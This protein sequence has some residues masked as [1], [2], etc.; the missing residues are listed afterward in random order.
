MTGVD[1]GY[2]W[3]VL[4][5]LFVV[6]TLVNYPWEIGQA[7]L[8]IGMDYSV[9]MWWHCFVASLGDGML[10]WIIYGVGRV[11]LRRSDW[12][13]VPGPQR[14]VVM[15]TSGLIIG[16][17]V[18]WLATHVFDRWSYTDQMP[19]IPV[20]DIGWVPVLQM[21]LLPPLVFRLVAGNSTAS[22]RHSKSAADN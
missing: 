7:F 19:L 21:L 8:Y 12:F 22:A 5:R 20:F 3:P 6:A 13:K 1:F 17:A 16:I 18:E 11:M 4:T 15:L 9:S 14:Y 10:V 2:R